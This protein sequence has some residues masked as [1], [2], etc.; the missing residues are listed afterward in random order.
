MEL[1]PTSSKETTAVEPV[2]TLSRDSRP[3]GSLPPFGVG[4]S[5][6]P[7]PI[8]LQTGLRFLR[9]PIPT[10]PR[11]NPCGPPSTILVETVGLTTLRTRTNPEGRRPRLSADSAS[12]AWG[13]HRTPR[14]DCPP[15]LVHAYQPPI[16]HERNPLIPGDRALLFVAGQRTAYWRG[17]I[18]HLTWCNSLIL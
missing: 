17:E 14:P 6:N 3:V 4:Q 12:S 10:R 8:R 5:S 2:R 13:E 11:V 7:Y 9:P 16:K 18:S 1:K 15:F